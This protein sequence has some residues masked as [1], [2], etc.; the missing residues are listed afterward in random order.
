MKL[1]NSDVKIIPQETHLLGVYKQI[2]L[3]GRTAYKSEDKITND[4][5]KAF[6]EM[7]MSRGHTAPLEQGTVYLDCPKK[8]YDKYSK[9][10]Y[11]KVNTY[12]EENDGPI[13]WVGDGVGYI[14]NK[15]HYYVTTNARVIY[16]NDWISDLFFLCDPT[17]HHSGRITAKF[18]CSR[19]V[20]NEIVR[21]RTFKYN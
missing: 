7:L 14:A 15:I 18:T 12:I 10:K 9:N 21:H 4:S 11:S 5:A 16:E 6:V 8:V 19:A 20:A 3:A 17:E 13:K 1:I 2:E